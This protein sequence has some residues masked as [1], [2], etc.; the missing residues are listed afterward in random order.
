MRLVLSTEPH[1]APDH[2]ANWFLMEVGMLLGFATSYPVDVW[3][4]RRGIKEAM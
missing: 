4:I 1:L 2:A 3:L